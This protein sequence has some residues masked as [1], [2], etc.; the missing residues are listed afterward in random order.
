MLNVPMPQSSC[1]VSQLRLLH[2]LL[3]HTMMALLC[4]SYLSCKVLMHFLA[5]FSE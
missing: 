3:T 1:V 4:L 5:V 2:I